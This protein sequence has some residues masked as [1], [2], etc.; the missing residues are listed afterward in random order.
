MAADTLE[1]R[2]ATLL[3]IRC[4][5]STRRTPSHRPGVPRERVNHRLV[6]CHRRHRCPCVL[7]H[8]YPVAAAWMHLEGSAGGH[9][10]PW[11]GRSVLACTS[12]GHWQTHHVRGAFPF[13]GGSGLACRSC[14]PVS[15]LAA[16]RRKRTWS[17][18]AR[19]PD[20]V[21]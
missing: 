19:A 2:S 8:R 9:T 15:F 10:P 18:R 16:G 6:L 21:R 13:A 17:L 1:L 7:K 5:R 12:L 11:R 14:A 20:R 3:R 4:T